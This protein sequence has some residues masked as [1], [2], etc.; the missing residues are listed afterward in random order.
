MEVQSMKCAEAEVDGKV[1]SVF[2]SPVG[3]AWK[4]SKKGRQMLIKHEGSFTTCPF[5]SV[6]QDELITV[7]ENG[8]ILKTYTFDEVRENASK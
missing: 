7:F 8:K 3:D 5:T 6:L 4:A 1:I 2:K